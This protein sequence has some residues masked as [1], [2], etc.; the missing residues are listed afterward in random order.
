MIGACRV[1]A[2]RGDA[3][4]AIR[5]AAEGHPDLATARVTIIDPDISDS[6]KQELATRLQDALVSPEDDL[7]DPTRWVVIAEAVRAEAEPGCGPDQRLGGLNYAAWHAHLS[8]T[9]RW[10]PDKDAGPSA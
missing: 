10:V 2:H 9:R 6:R 8:G 4:F 3:A 1:T 7:R 5:L